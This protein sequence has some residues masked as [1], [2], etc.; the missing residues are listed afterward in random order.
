MLKPT[1]AL[2]GLMALAGC[3][4]H[5]G[6][7]AGHGKMDHAAH[8]AEMAQTRRQ[9]EVAQRGAEVMP[10]SLAATVHVF[11]RTQRG[12][13]QRVLA[14]DPADAVQVNLVR[15]HLQEIRGQF[16]RGDFSGPA[17][18]HGANMPGLAELQA[19]KPGQLAIAYRDVPGG[20]ELD[21]TT[22]EPALVQAL[23]RWFD[24]QLADHG[25]DATPGHVH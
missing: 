8:R 7:H 3:A 2:L 11:T 16:L 18:I 4:H 12:G 10:F 21:Y 1:L 13:V 25:R 14:R 17:R 5:A 24:A 9:A 19:A 15:Q 6:P 22:A 20:A 23:H